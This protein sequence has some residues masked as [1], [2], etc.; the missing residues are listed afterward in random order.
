MK[1]KHITYVTIESACPA[2]VVAI[3]VLANVILIGVV[4]GVVVL[5]VTWVSGW[6]TSQCRGSGDE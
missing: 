1:P 2:D 4:L 6:A 5:L 3:D